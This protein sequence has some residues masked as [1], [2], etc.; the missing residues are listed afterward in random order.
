MERTISRHG[1]FISRH[2]RFIF[3]TWMLRINIPAR[4][5]RHDC[6]R[7]LSHPSKWCSAELCA[8]VDPPIH[9]IP[10]NLLTL[11]FHFPFSSSIFLNKVSFAYAWLPS[12]CLLNVAVFLSLRIISMTCRRN[13]PS[14]RMFRSVHDVRNCGWIILLS[15]RML[16]LLLFRFVMFTEAC[17]I[18]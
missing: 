4:C 6:Y 13:F 18:I 17:E 10:P 1:R 5:I 7:Q 2:G 9:F 16:L 14:Y 3:K 8:I 15:P 12:S 11:R